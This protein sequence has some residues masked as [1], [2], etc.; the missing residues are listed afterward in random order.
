MFYLASPP[1]PERTTFLDGRTSSLARWA[2]TRAAAARP[3]AAR[4]RGVVR[5]GDRKTDRDR[6]RVA[7]RVVSRERQHVRAVLLLRIDVVGGVGRGVLSAAVFSDE[8]SE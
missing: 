8:I 3:R 6:R 1:L 4:G 2:L 7:V 5:A